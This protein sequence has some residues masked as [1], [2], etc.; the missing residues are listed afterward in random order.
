MPTDADLECRELRRGGLDF[1]MQLAE[2]KEE[3]LRM[4]DEFEPD[5]I[6][7]DFSLPTFDGLSA[8]DIAQ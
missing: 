3:F 8:L 2:T 5:V 7:S 4:L 6:L 1:V